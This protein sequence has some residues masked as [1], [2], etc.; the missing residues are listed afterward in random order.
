MSSEVIV[1]TQ[2]GCPTCNQLKK[3]LENRH[4]AF[5]ERDVSADES[6]YQELHDRGYAATPLTVIGEVEI[7]GLNRAKFDA[8]LGAPQGVTS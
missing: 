5:T 4:V 3:Y 8:V 7:L 1:F 6:A 2:P